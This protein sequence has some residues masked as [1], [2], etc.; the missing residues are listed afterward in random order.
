[1][2]FI[3]NHLKYQKVNHILFSAERKY[4]PRILELHLN[5]SEAL[6]EILNSI[7]QWKPESNAKTMCYEMRLRFVIDKWVRI[8]VIQLTIWNAA[9]EYLTR[10]STLDTGRLSLRCTE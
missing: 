4:S 1:M 7:F 8:M 10:S 5:V 3:R 2:Y 9:L 6:A